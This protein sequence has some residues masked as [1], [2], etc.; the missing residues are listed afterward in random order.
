MWLC[1]SHKYWIYG[2]LLNATIVEKFAH[3]HELNDFQKNNPNKLTLE[4]N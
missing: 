2:S 4:L 1:A 3:F